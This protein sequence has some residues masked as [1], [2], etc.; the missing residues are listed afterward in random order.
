MPQGPLLALKE[1]SYLKE[2]PQ[3]SLKLF[4]SLV[5]GS[6]SLVYQEMKYVSFRSLLLFYNFKESENIAFT[7]NQFISID[8][9]GLIKPP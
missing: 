1:T 8:K 5:G 3:K 7:G 2:P 9:K 4:S 6:L